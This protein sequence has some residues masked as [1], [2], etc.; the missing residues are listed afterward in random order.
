MS[1]RLPLILAV[2]LLAT[3]TLYAAEPPPPVPAKGDVKA[4]T[5]EAIKKAQKFLIDNANEDG[6]FGKGFAHGV[7]G[8]VALATYGLASGP[9]KLTADKAPALAKA[10]EY[11]VGKQDAKGAIWIPKFQN[12][13]YN[14]STAVMALKALNDPKYNEV[15]DKAK[16][17][18]LNC[19]LDEKAGYEKD[20]HIRSYGGFAYAMSLQANLSNTI[21][22]MDALK[23]LGLKEDSPAFK[24]ALTFVRRCQ[25]NLETNDSPEMKF[26]DNAGGFVY[27]P[28]ESEH[29]TFKTRA[30]KEAPVPYGN[31]SFQGLRALLYCGLGKDSPEVKAAMKYI[32]ANYDVK[33]QPGLPDASKGQGYFYYTVALARCLSVYGESELDLG[34]GKKAAWGNDLGGY[35]AT[36]QKADGSF[37]NPV[38]RWQ[39]NDPILCTSYALIALNLAYENIK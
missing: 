3:A 38:D 39:E 22:A 25:D 31:M 13:N 9:A 12:A 15:L 10:A 28:G 27:L 16:E 2:M 30:G 11:L 18:I 23:D 20:V 5:L 17:F 8:V 26:G 34:G 7:P 19:Q 29:D 1:Y 37:V 4:Q 36:I 14:T 32:R 21:F 6:T 35:L 33:N 24:N